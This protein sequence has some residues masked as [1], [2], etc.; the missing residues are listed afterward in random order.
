MLCYA[1]SLQSCL[2]LCDPI[3]G[4]PPGSPIPGILQARTLEWVTLLPS[5][6]NRLSLSFCLLICNMGVILASRFLEQWTQSSCAVPGMWQVIHSQC[7]LWSCLPLPALCCQTL[8]T[9]SQVL[10][11]PNNLP[12]VTEHISE[13]IGGYPSISWFPGFCW[14]RLSPH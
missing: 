6:G 7:L 8:L 9:E 2:T 14:A 4:S 1:K 5:C 13:E 10:H 11:R 3:D 12:K